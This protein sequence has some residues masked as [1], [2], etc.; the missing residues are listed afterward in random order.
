MFNEYVRGAFAFLCV[1]AVDICMIGRTLRPLTFS[2]TMKFQKY[3]IKYVEC[4]VEMLIKRLMEMEV[5]DSD[6][7][8]T[9]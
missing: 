8:G 7:Q 9:F 6:W 5:L 2:I 3:T 1:G 4:C